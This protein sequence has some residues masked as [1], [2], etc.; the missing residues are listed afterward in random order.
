MNAM[1]FGGSGDLKM[2]QIYTQYVSMVPEWLTQIVN[3]RVWNKEGIM[4]FQATALKDENVETIELDIP[5]EA[6]RWATDNRLRSYELRIRQ[7][8]EWD[9]RIEQL[10]NW[11]AWRGAG[12]VKHIEQLF[13]R[14]RNRNCNLR[15]EFD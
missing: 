14:N 6:P 1:V 7:L 13:F 4:T 5:F 10:N 15:G 11:T 2:R 8:R 12:F 9:T 3:A